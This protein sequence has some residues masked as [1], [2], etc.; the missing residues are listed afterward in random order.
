MK[1]FFT[2]LFASLLLSSKAQQSDTS[3]FALI[4]S[5]HGDIVDA[6]VDNLDNLYLISSKGQLTKFDA[7]GDSISV[8]SQSKNL[9]RPTSIDV[10][11]PLKVLLF[12]K[13]FSTVVVV[14]RML[15]PRAT[16]NLR[17]SAVLNPSAVGL[18]YDNNIWVFDDYDSKL[19]KLDE[20]GTVQFQSSDFRTLFQKT[21]SPAKIIS[22][23]GFVFLADS[24]HGIFVFDNYGT[25]KRTIPLKNWSSISFHNGTIIRS[26]TDEILV[27][28][29]MNFIDKITKVPSSFRPYLRS[30]I[31]NNWFVTISADSASIYRF[32]L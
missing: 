8:Y 7:R 9:G 20:R 6:V 29:P 16:L 21:I 26:A 30:F 11:N 13:D 32:H 3:G 28:D 4:R 31:T 25:Y 18:A 24:S 5:Y 14:D 19:K 15:A 1:L 10:S 2:I 22:D 27:Y 17:K 23:A 12:Y